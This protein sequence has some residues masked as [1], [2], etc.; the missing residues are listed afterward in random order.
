MENNT[1]KLTLSI[2]SVMVI[3]G[4]IILGVLSLR[5]HE[6]AIGAMIALLSQGSGYF[7]RGRMSN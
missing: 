7:L 2:G 6:L 1:E 4:S 3:V 5:G